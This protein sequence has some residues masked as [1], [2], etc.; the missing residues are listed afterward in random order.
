VSVSTSVTLGVA[1]SVA[2]DVIMRIAGFVAGC[3][4]RRREPRG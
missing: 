2:S 1:S 3:E 4:R